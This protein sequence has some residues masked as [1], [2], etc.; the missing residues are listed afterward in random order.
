MTSVL[1]ILYFGVRNVRG[2]GFQVWDIAAFTTFLSCFSKLSQKSSS[3]AKL[4]N[5]IQKAQVSW[6]RIQPI[7]AESSGDA[8]GKSTLGRAFLC[9]Q[10]Y[11]SSILWNG[12]ELS[13]MSP[14]L[15]R[16]IVGYLGHDPE[17]M[18]DTIAD[19][20][21][22]GSPQDPAPYLHAVCLDKDLSQMEGGSDTRIGC[23]GALHRKPTRNG[24][25]P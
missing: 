6:A 5:S 1:L 11:L 2:T 13:G 14:E 7:L 24:V 16:H 4:F 20:I 12:Q 23:G 8:A 9:E 18:S 17:L 25:L 21:L 19:N 10:P 22:L 3:A 15:Q